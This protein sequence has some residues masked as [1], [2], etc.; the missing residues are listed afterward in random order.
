[1]SSILVFQAA[2]VAG[3]FAACAAQAAEKPALSPAQSQLLST[4]SAD[5][6]RGHLAFLSSDAL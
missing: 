6:M 1:M 5:A 2:V 3:M 4:I